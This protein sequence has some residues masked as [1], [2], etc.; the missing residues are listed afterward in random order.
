MK[1]NFKY[2]VLTGIAALA[3]ACMEFLAVSHPDS[4][5]VNTGV[6]VSFE[7]KVKVAELIGERKTMVV[8]ILAPTVWNMAENAVITYSSDDMPGGAVKDLPMRLATDGDL[9][10]DGTAWAASMTSKLGTQGNYEPVEWTA[11]LSE[12]E[13][14]W[15]DNDEF[16]GT[17]RIRFTTGAENIRTYLAYFIGNTNDAV[18]DDPQYYLLHKQLFE[19]VGG[20]SATTD[21]TQ[22]KMCSIQPDAFT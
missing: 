2:P 14:S 1:R 16:T 22:P 6:D 7:V 21:Y 11:F 12:T 20:E 4:A 9:T 15:V 18:N 17:V 13:H 8:G 5:P 19:T 3:A 10:P